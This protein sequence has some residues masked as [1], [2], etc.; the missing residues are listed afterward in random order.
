[1]IGFLMNG[2]VT[3]LGEQVTGLLTALL[4]FLTNHIFTSPDVTGLPQVRNIAEHSAFVV[5]TAYILAIITAGVMSMVSTSMEVRYGIKELVPRLVVGF[6]LSAFAIPLCSSLIE[7]A[8]AVVV[9][10]VGDTAPTTQTA[11]MARTHVAAAMTDQST[12]LVAVI[13]GVV[14]VVLMCMLL[15]GFVVRIAVLVVLAGIAPVALACYAL[16]YSQP[17]VQLW[18]RSLL[19]CLATPTLQAIAFSTGIDLLLDPTANMPVLIGLPGSDLVNLLLVVVV[20]WVTV[21]IPGLVRRYITRKGGVNAGGIIARSVLVST[22]TRRL[23]R[24]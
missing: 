7:V 11:T 15:G 6:V 4:D 20:L 10:M 1:M 17:A 23:G 18:W 5:S 24:I 13:V 22:I 2:L 8:N 16:P 12:A 21:K 3:W 14:I 9:A 19:G